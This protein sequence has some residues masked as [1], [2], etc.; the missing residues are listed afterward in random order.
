[1]KSRQR[2]DPRCAVWWPR[3]KRGRTRRGLL[4]ASSRW[5]WSAVLQVPVLLL[6]VHTAQA[7]PPGERAQSQ[8]VAGSTSSAVTAAGTLRAAD[9]DLLVAS[10]PE[11][12]ATRLLA[13]GQ[14]EFL[15]GDTSA[16]LRTLE[17]CTRLYAQTLAGAQASALRGLLL[18]SVGR[19]VEAALESESPEAAPML[20]D[21][22]LERC[23]AAALRAGD[24]GAAEQVLTLWRAADHWGAP[25]AAYAL[26]V[27]Q[28]CLDRHQEERA[29]RWLEPA[30]AARP[31]LQVVPE[32]LCWL[33]AVYAARGDSRRAEETLARI[34]ASGAA[35]AVSRARA[36]HADL[37]Y[38]DRNYARAQRLYAELLAE[39]VAQVEREWARYQMGN[40]AAAL[41]DPVVA[42]AWL[43][44]VSAQR[45]SFWTAHARLRLIELAEVY[46]VGHRP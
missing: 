2:T 44:Q 10:A 37:L 46:G 22:L 25:W 35:P 39:G 3:D 17:T 21:D 7:V 4:G 27:A 30:L 36:A 23:G 45:E 19:A 1:M 29:L 13:A 43:S 42:M 9:T 28:A 20:R 33:A 26:C 18:R 38:R 40:C 11:C 15:Q 5:A 41:G 34:E 8:P 12:A 16:A 6:V 24:L 14:E 32:V 31:E